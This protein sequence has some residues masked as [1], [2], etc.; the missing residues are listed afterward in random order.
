MYTP[1]LSGQTRVERHQG[2]LEE[3]KPLLEQTV[4]GGQQSEDP[5]EGGSRRKISVTP[6]TSTSADCLGSEYVEES[7]PLLEQK[8]MDEQQLEDSREGGSRTNFASTPLTSEVTIKEGPEPG[9]GH[10]GPKG[11]K[12]LKGPR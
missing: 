6:S 10:K 1:L 11:P 12:E 4:V 5:D 3:T 2:G 9:L 7:K 8:V